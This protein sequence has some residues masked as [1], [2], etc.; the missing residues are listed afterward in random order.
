M[1]FSNPLPATTPSKPALPLRPIILVAAATT[2][3]LLATFP[4]CNYPPGYGLDIS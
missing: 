1:P 3:L 4:N 2:Y